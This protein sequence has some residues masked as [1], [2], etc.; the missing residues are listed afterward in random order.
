MA[1]RLLQQLKMKILE[2]LQV[3]T[4]SGFLD[5]G[6]TLQALDSTSGLADRGRNSIRNGSS[7]LLIGCGG[8]KGTSSSQ[9]IGIGLSTHEESPTI[10]KTGFH[11][12]RK[13]S[14]C[15]SPVAFLTTSENAPTTGITN[16]NFGPT[17]D[18]LLLGGA[19]QI[20]GPFLGAIS[21]GYGGGG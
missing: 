1:R 16:L 3:Q 18:A 15:N 21:G 19:G 12:S 10:A 6:T 13:Q 9:P 2:A 20:G 17:A 14:L 7:K 4:I 8:L 5:T 11:W